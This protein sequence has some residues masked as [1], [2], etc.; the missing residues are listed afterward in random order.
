MSPPHPAPRPAA[1]VIIARDTPQ[2]LEVFMMRRS[3]QMVF[4]GGN[5]VFPGGALDASD[6]DAAWEALCEGL[7]AQQANDLLSLDEG[8]LAYWVAALR[9]CFEESG[10]LLCRDAQGELVTHHD[11]ALTGE[12]AELRAA[13][14]AGKLRFLDLLRDRGLRAALDQVVYFSH[15]ITPPGGPR[16]YDTRFFVTAVPLQQTASHDNAEA[17]HHAWL[18]PADALERQRNGEIQMIFPTIKTLE[19]L[20]KFPDCAALMAYARTPRDIPAILPRRATGRD[21]RRVLRPGDAA[22]AEVGKL[23]PDLLGTASY[24]I[25]PGVTTR[26]S[27]RVRRI[28][29]PNPGFMTGPGTNSYLIG[30][31]PDIAIIDP[32]PAIPAH[33][34]ALLAE[35]QR[36]GG[37]VRWLLATHTHTDHSPAAAAIR[38][39]TGAELI[40]R[41]PPEHGNQDRQFLPTRVPESGERLA[42]AGCT[43]RVLHTPGH[44]SNQVVY[45]LEEESMLFTGDHVMQ[46][47]TVVIGPPDG[48]M[49]DYFASLRAAQGL[50]AAWI[51]PGHGFLIADGRRAI[52]RIIRHREEREAKVLAALRALSQEQGSGTLEELVVKA[53][54][55]VP[56]KVHPVASRSLHAHLLKLQAEGRVRRDGERWAAPAGI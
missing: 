37:R 32:G 47:S 43:L 35:A 29:A 33:V 30:E 24:E 6:H 12:L 13:L 41:P 2:G 18:R 51:A 26:L 17:D 21:G 39:R 50:G 44:A 42:I 38:E 54:D 1:T 11:E 40:G 20:A 15:W 52:A 9:E 4:V 53:Y 49:I 55:D 5:Y 56:A 34:E 3:E 45:L 27:P 36:D 46:G 19:V 25:I 16:R 31:G 14:N 10:L 23:D 8:G 28:T 48:N 7:D 22:Y